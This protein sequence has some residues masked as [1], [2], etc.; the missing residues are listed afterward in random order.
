MGLGL[1]QPHTPSFHNR[2]H[3]AMARTKM[4]ARRSPYPQWKPTQPFL[5]KTEP[6]DG[7]ICICSKSKRNK[8]KGTCHECRKKRR[9]AKRRAQLGE[10][11]SQ[12]TTDQVEGTI[13]KNQGVFDGG[14]K[15]P[16]CDVTTTGETDNSGL[17]EANVLQ[18]SEDDKPQESADI[19]CID[20]TDDVDVPMSLSRDSRKRRH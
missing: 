13:A 3:S 9:K 5:P 19:E 7:G 2:Q 8:G 18:I 10:T 16:P 11:Q 6:V 1:L 20:L 17:V 14:I 12:H 4:T 15:L